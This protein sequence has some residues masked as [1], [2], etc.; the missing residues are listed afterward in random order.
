M[1][2]AW[3]ETADSGLCR[4]GQCYTRQKGRDK[5]SLILRY[6]VVVCLCNTQL[7]LLKW[8]T[9]IWQGTVT[10]ITGTRPPGQRRVLLLVYK[11]YTGQDL[12]VIVTFVATVHIGQ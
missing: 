2:V 5:F 6:D 10:Y 8:K 1:V 9:E 11:I 3:Q 7:V 12:T 4:R